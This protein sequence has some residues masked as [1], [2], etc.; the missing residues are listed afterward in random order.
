MEKFHWLPPRDKLGKNQNAF[1]W[2]HNALWIILFCRC[3][4][5][6]ILWTIMTV[7][8]ILWIS[9]IPRGQKPHPYDKGAKKASSF[10]WSWI[11]TVLWAS[12]NAILHP[13][14]KNSLVAAQMLIAWRVNEKWIIICTKA[15]AVITT[16]KK[17]E[18]LIVCTWLI[19]LRLVG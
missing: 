19:D 13:K 1:T 12:C 18:L 3:I 2:I 10:F 7:T 9:F 5:M 15:I 16:M 4:L 17:Q 11:S 14:K 8:L 6:T